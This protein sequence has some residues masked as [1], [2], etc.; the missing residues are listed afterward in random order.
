MLFSISHTSNLTHFQSHIIQISHTSNL[1][2]FQS[3]T[4]P[5][6]HSS[7]LAFF[8]SHTL[9]ISHSFRFTLFQ[10]YTQLRI[11]EEKNCEL[12][13]T[14]FTSLTKHAIQSF[15]FTSYWTCIFSIGLKRRP[16][17]ILEAWP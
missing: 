8:Q 7:N 5:I 4:L 9:S 14:Y 17:F 11:W 12:F 13:P 3:H 1:T 16:G 2:L 6:S 15:A 10:S